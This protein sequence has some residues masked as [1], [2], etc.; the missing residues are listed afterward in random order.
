MQSNHFLTGKGHQKQAAQEAG[1]L[2]HKPSKGPGA[3]KRSGPLARDDGKN[4]SGLSWGLGIVLA[5]SLLTSPPP[6]L[7]PALPCSPRTT[8]GNP[9]LAAASAPTLCSAQLATAQAGPCVASQATHK[10]PRILQSLHLSLALPSPPSGWF[11][12]WLPRSPCP[13]PSLCT[14]SGNNNNSNNNHRSPTPEFLPRE[15]HGQRSLQSIGTHK[16]GHD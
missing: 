4:S 3:K 9:G 16:V 6:P 12:S 14:K 10:A 13:T 2:D 11:L 5:S 8:A 15:S 1:R 7:A